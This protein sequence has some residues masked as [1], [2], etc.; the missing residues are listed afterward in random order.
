MYLKKKK[1]KKE[2]KKGKAAVLPVVHRL[3]NLPANAGDMGL[4]S[5]PRRSPMLPK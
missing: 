1:K 4:I 3:K 5:G 2:R